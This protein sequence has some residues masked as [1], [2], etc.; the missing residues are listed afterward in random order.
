ML[1]LIIYAA[2]GLVCVAASAH[3]GNVARSVTPF[4][5]TF[6]HSRHG[7]LNLR[8]LDWNPDM[9]NCASQCAV[10][11]NAFSCP[12]SQCFCTDE[13][14]AGFRDCMV[15]SIHLA[16]LPSL[17]PDAQESQ[18]ELTEN[19][20]SDGYPI[21]KLTVTTN[22][23][24]PDIPPDDQTSVVMVP[25]IGQTSTVYLHAPT[26]TAPAGGQ[27]FPGTTY[28]WQPSPTTVTTDGATVWYGGSSFGLAMGFS[29]NAAQASD[30]TA[31]VT[32]SGFQT[33]VTFPAPA[34]NTV[35]ANGGAS[36]SAA[37]GGASPNATDAALNPQETNTSGTLASRTIPCISLVITLAGVVFSHI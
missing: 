25:P 28:P 21:A 29:T 31:T 3:T 16:Q 10:L 27:Q 13:I 33:A 34:D 26:A 17:L 15:C 9:V 32:I 20:N 18:D 14:A 6:V 35:L 19:C 23:V 37:T 30:T 4:K 22:G 36:G 7:E 2:L 11:V 1:S 5:K 8:D 24:G 12:T